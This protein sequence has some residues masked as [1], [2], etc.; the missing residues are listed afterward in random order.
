[1]DKKTA[2]IDPTIL[3]FL[4]SWF[5]T[6]NRWHGKKDNSLKLLRKIDRFMKERKI[7]PRPPSTPEER[8]KT[9]EDLDVALKKAAEILI[10][11]KKKKI[12]HE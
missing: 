11:K 10:S 4:N 3:L 5:R 7:E 9:E 1:M 2:K 12:K 8:K 6:L